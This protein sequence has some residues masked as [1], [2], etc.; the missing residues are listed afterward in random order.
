MVSFGKTRPD[1]ALIE[2]AV[3][4]CLFWLGHCVN[5]SGQGISTS[6]GMGLNLVNTILPRN[7]GILVITGSILAE[8]SL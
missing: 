2:A 1:A 4:D 3:Y 5:R 6:T 8:N 7:I